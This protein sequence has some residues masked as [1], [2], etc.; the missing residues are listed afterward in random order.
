[1]F[2]SRARLLS[3][4]TEEITAVIAAG[5]YATRLGCKYP[6]PFIEVDHIPLLRHWLFQIN[7]IGIT[8]ILVFTN[9]P[10]WYS[11]TEAACDGFPARVETDKGFSCSLELAKLALRYTDAS[12]ILFFLIMDSNNAS[13]LFFTLLHSF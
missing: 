10:E 11:A 13:L 2:G 1:M 12:K 5:G 6:K 3:P 9:R 7:R 8:N 4:N